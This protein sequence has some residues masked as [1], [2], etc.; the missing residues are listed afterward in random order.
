MIGGRLSHLHQ[1]SHLHDS[2][3]SDATG[4]S[5]VL[6]SR[7]RNPAAVSYRLLAQRPV[8]MEVGKY[9]ERAKTIEIWPS[10]SRSFSLVA[11]CFDLSNF[12][13]IPRRECFVLLRR[14]IAGDASAPV[15]FVRRPL[16]GGYFAQL[17]LPR[18]LR[19]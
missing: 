10:G 9:L 19:R 3:L 5:P 14:C 18:C 6:T 4:V 15:E 2:A 16:A 1:L 17:D 7:L 11:R 12:A 8:I 13:P